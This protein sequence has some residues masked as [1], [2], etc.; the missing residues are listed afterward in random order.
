MRKLEIVT[1]FTLNIFLS[2]PRVHLALDHV[3]RTAICHSMVLKTECS[4]CKNQFGL[5][6]N[7]SHGSSQSVF[8][9]CLGLIWRLLL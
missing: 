3:A 7:L 1:N 2:S 5:G 6:V 9:T 4:K 8:Q